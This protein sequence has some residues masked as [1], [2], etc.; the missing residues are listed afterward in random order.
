MCSASRLGLGYPNK[1]YYAR[2]HPRVAALFGST[3]LRGD[4]VVLDDDLQANTD[5]Y[6]REM[7][8]SSSPPV[9]G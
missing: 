2:R 9:S 8:A 1:A 7:R 6:I 3:L 4:A 5:R